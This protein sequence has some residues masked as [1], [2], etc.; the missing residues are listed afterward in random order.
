[1]AL[2]IAVRLEMWPVLRYCQWV[3]FAAVVV[4]GV[5]SYGL[6]IYYL[7]GLCAVLSGAVLFLQSDWQASLAASLDQAGFLLAFV[8]LIGLLHNGAQSSLSIKVAGSY[9]TALQ[10]LPRSFSLYFGTGFMSILFNLGIISFL[11]PLIQRGVKNVWGDATEA[12][13][14]ERSQMSSM[15]RGFGWGVIWSP[16]AIAP[17]ILI[18]LLPEADRKL[19][20]V[21]GVWIRDFF[22]YGAGQFSGGRASFTRCRTRP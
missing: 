2:A 5:K 1:M 7:I 15:L 16:T 14:D 10:P 11:V 21:Y 9:L 4:S 13:R 8:L 18:E 6:R 22:V 17:V 20:M 19:W 3:V 12:I